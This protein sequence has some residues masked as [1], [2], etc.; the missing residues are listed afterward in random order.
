MMMKSLQLNMLALVE[1][2]FYIIV[3]LRNKE[4]Q[5]R[6]DVV[7]ILIE[8]LHSTNAYVLFVNCEKNWNCPVIYI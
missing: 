3:C 6:S 4:I 8:C 7:L 2:E 5:M 1:Q